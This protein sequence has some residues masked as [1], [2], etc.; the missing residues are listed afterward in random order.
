MVIGIDSSAGHIASFYNIPSITLWG[1]F[2]PVKFWNSYNGYRA[3]RKNYSI[4]PCD[5]N[6]RSVKY[7]VVYDV[8]TKCLSGEIQFKE[9]IITYQDSLDGYTVSLIEFENQGEI[10]AV[11][12]F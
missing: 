7:D 4:V 8:L 12:L 11:P 3:L 9:E 1:G 10:M 6:L 2:S 5:Q